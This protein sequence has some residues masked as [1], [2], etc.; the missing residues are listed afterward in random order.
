MLQS[1]VLLPDWNLKITNT[2][3]CTAYVT[4]V[5]AETS[6]TVSRMLL[7]QIPKTSAQPTF[8]ICY[9]MVIPA[10]LLILTI[11]SL[12]EQYLSESQHRIS[13]G[14]K[15]I[16]KQ[17]VNTFDDSGYFFYPFTYLY[18]FSFH[19]FFCLLLFL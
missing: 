4:V 13:S 9:C 12:N 11:T 10:S 16:I 8:V 2:F 15:Q 1:H 5:I 14:S 3:S 6:L 17:I 18:G 19:V 7:M